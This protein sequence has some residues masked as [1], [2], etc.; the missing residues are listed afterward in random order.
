MDFK[1]KRLH[2]YSNDALLQELRRVAHAV[3]IEHLTIK[4][5]K[6]HGRVSASTIQ[7]GFGRLLEEMP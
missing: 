6:E 1:L 5:F 7:K 4:L 2:D 3:P